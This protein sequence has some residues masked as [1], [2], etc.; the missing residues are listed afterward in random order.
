MKLKDIK[1]MI[2]IGIVE[3]VTTKNQA[4][5]DKLEIM[6]KVYSYGGYGMNGCLFK[7]VNGKIY[8]IIGRNTNLWRI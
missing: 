7:D 2:E 4:F 1:N 3:D 6:E 5:F 8:A